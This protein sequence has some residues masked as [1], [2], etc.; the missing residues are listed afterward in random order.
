MKFEIGDTVRVVAII[1]DDP[2]D[3]DVAVGYVGEIVGVWDDDEY[4]YEL[5]GSNGFKEEE[6]ELVEK[7]VQ[8]S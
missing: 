6:L 3:G 8:Q 5:E 2:F 4:P 1:G 7:G